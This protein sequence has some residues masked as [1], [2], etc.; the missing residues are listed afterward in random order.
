M[1]APLKAQALP[2]GIFA[3]YP[4][5]RHLSG[6]VRALV[7]FLVDR[8]CPEPPWDRALAER[9]LLEID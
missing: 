7:D 3:I 1:S 8:F 6:R 2:N 5:N 4:E 9:G